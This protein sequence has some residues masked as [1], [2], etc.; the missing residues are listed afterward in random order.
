MVRGPIEDAVWAQLDQ[1]ADG[2]VAGRGGGGRGAARPGRMPAAVRRQ[3]LGRGW[4]A[5]RW[6]PGGMGLAVLGVPVLLA[7]GFWLVVAGSAG[8]P[9]LAWVG[10]SALVLV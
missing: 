8:G 6:G 4:L 5:L 9:P 1:Q 2:A 3:L 10:A 7:G